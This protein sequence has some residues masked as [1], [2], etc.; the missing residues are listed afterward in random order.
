MALDLQDDVSQSEK[1]NRKSPLFWAA[2]VTAAL[3]L[4]A[5]LTVGGVFFW[6]KQSLAPKDP[7]AHIKIHF[8][9]TPG[10]SN[11]VIAKEL[12]R[13]GLIQNAKS[14]EW[15]LRF[16]KPGRVL[17]SGRYA[18]SP[19]WSSEQIIK[20]LE[21]GKTDVLRITIYPGNTTKDIKKTLKKYGYA[22]SEIE[23]ALSAPYNHP[24]LAD[25]PAGHDLEGYIFPETFEIN[26]GETLK[27]FLQRD[28]DTLY[29]RLKSDGMIEK[30]RSRNLNLHQ[31]LTL[32]S[33]IQMETSDF[34]EQKKAAQVFYKR[35]ASDM[36]LETDPTFIYAAEKLGVE[37]TVSVNSPYNTRLHKGLPPGPIANMNYS[38]LQAVAEPAATDFLY[39]VAGDNGVTHFSYTLEEHEANVQKYCRELCN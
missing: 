26:S 24:L 5:L 22:E 34:E 30:F 9:V 3:L 16:E 23:S 7:N 4:V 36:K 28:F 32:A 18:L 1:K 39:F 6:Y 12:E 35:L 27:V 17:Q 13:K 11:T 14:L 21:E 2:W 20:H 38:A 33:I 25:R 31:A 37:P 15:Y 10:Q 29:N 19:R 8:M